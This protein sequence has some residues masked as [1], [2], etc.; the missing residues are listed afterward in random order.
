M[1]SRRYRMGHGYRK[2]GHGATPHD[3]VDP[4]VAVVG[5]VG[6]IQDDHSAQRQCAG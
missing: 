1:A 2:S 5:M 6:A 4:V 3:C